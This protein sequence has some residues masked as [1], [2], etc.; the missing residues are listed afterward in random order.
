MLTAIDFETRPNLIFQKQQNQLFFTSNHISVPGIPQYHINQTGLFSYFDV[1]DV[2]LGPAIGPAN[3]NDFRFHAAFDAPDGLGK[4]QY[5]VIPGD[6]PY[7]ARPDSERN[8]IAWTAFDPAD[9]NGVA[10][11]IGQL[12]NG[13]HH[14]LV[15]ALSPA[16]IQSA[17]ADIPFIYDVL[18]PELSFVLSTNSPTGPNDAMLTTTVNC[19]PLGAAPVFTNAFFTANGTRLQPYY[20]GN[21]NGKSDNSV[22]YEMKWP[23]VA[24]NIIQAC[25]NGATIRF[26]VENIADGAGNVAPPVEAT[27]RLDYA[28][29]KTPP[30]ATPTLGNVGV[31]HGKSGFPTREA[32]F[33]Q[34]AP[35]LGAGRHVI[36][37][38][39]GMQSQSLVLKV[40]GDPNPKDGQNRIASL[41]FQNWIAPT[42]RWLM[43]RAR[44]PEKTQ[45]PTGVVFRLAFTV[46]ATPKEAK[47]PAKNNRYVLEV[48]ASN[49]TNDA[50]RPAGLRGNTDFTPGN[51]VELAIDVA[52]FLNDKAGIT[53]GAFK[54]DRLA[55]ILPPVKGGALELDAAAVVRSVPAAKRSLD[56]NAYDVSGID[57]LYVGD[58]K[59]A[60]GSRIILEKLYEKCGSKFFAD[61]RI[62]DRAG[63]TAPMA[64][65]IPLPPLD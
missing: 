63:N 49:S 22:S 32:F 38:A 54:I 3:T 2:A 6:M 37:N 24:R 55:L 13:M 8:S 27:Y 34:F 39:N 29:D 7:D 9:T 31:I 65:I 51:W 5:A 21:V 25:T 26:R 28:S 48:P 41:Q 19:G 15:R 12:A 46:N 23:Y 58:T 35:G 10:P 42:N 43:F 40:A 52:A 61:I 44:V 53:N 56:F 45:A 33:T 1:D 14:L 62:R 4:A 17:V 60:E 11:P 18:P 47:T 59:I 36:T 64:A 30:M 57:G 20:M 50:A 16:G